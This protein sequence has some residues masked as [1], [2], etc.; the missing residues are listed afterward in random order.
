MSRG[1]FAKIL[2]VPLAT[3]RAWEKGRRNPSGAAARLLDMVDQMPDLVED[4]VYPLLEIPEPHGRRATAGSST[5]RRAMTAWAMTGRASAA[6]TSQAV[7]GTFAYKKSKT[8]HPATAPKTAATKGARPKRIKEGTLE[9]T[10]E[11]S[12][13]LMKGGYV[14]ISD[15]ERGEIEVRMLFDED[16]PGLKGKRLRI[17]VFKA[18]A[19][20]RGTVSPP[21]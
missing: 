7:A 3:L 10:I 14:K 1:A 2:N 8:A 16:R 11:E 19:A 6:K 21:D 9:L 13:R 4:F 20:L 17:T 15:P 12:N 5:P 18:G